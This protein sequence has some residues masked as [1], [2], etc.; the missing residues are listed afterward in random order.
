MKQIEDE[1]SQFEN[2][3]NNVLDSS[4]EDLHPDIRR[5]LNKARIKALQAKPINPFFKSTILKT[6]GALSLV[7]LIALVT[8]DNNQDELSSSDEIVDA[9][10]NLDKIEL[11][12]LALDALDLKALELEDQELLEQLEFAL[13]MA[14]ENQI[15]SL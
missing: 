4:V 3:I 11:D 13:W 6:A 14:E 15:A 9:K 5:K 2:R 7:T 8:L 10:D 12:E 1:Y